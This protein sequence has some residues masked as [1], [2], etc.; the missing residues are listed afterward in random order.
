MNKLTEILGIEKPII[1]APMHSMINAKLVAAVS[2]AGGL[3]IF[4]VNP[5]LD[6]EPEQKLSATEKMRLAIKEVKDV[7]ANPFAVQIL[8]T[9]DQ[10]EEDKSAYEMFKLVVEEHVPIVMVG[11]F[12]QSPSKEWVDLFHSKNIKVI[13]RPNHNTVEDTE[14]AL[15]A[16]V[17]VIG[18]TGFEAGGEPTYLGLMDIL[19]VMVDMAGDTPVFAA[20]GIADP[21]QVRAA[22]A[23]GAQAV[24]VGTAFLVAEE[25]AIANNIK[26]LMCKSTI[27]DLESF[28]A[29]PRFFRTLHGELPDRLKEMEEK[30]KSAEEIYEAAH[31]FMGLYYGDVMGD[32]SK[33][34]TGTGLGVSFTNKI[35]PAANIVDRLNEGTK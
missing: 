15:A 17:D 29:V 16:G 34:F 13:Y 5:I 35:E 8:I 7:T 14:K 18:A 1:Q 6:N 24:Y 32:L 3:G 31:K 20:G 2:K 22:F 10:P 27:F 21:R 9:K 30:G 12:N 19:P 23:L 28:N 26:E 4:G 11:G 25:A 33:G